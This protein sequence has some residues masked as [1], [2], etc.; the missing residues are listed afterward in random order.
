MRKSLG[1]GIGGGRVAQSPCRTSDCKGA[2]FLPK[3]AHSLRER[4]L[5]Q[6]DLNKCHFAVA[7]LHGVDLKTFTD[8]FSKNVCSL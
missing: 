2:E 8:M 3:K 1:G 4:M 6:G 5:S 7:A